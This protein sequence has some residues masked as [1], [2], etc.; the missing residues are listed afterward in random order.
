MHTTEFELLETLQK[1]LCV[2]CH[3]A[4]KSAHDY[5]AGVLA[6]GVND[7]KVRADWRRRGG[8]CAKHWRIL[9]SLP[10]PA[11]AASIL[12]EDLL[13]SYLAEG[14]PEL[15]CPA[16]ETEAEAARRYLQ[17]LTKMDERRVRESLERG[18]GFLCLKH[19][20]KLP[21]GRLAEAFKERLETLLAELKEF[22]R[23]QDYRFAAEPLGEERDSW[24]RAMRALGGEM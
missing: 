23:K 2:I 3:L 9:R 6:D 13:Q 10:N 5:L 18:R 24:L 14:L 8:L 11:L 12:T 15:R 17:A 22:E 19:L 21:Q 4:A 1:P 16:C 7:P 20:E